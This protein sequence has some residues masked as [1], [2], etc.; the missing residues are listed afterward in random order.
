MG[1]D[2]NGIRSVESR[3]ADGGDDDNGV[4]TNER[5]KMNLP[6][7]LHGY[8]SSRPLRSPTVLVDDDTADREVWAIGRLSIEMREKSRL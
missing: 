5:R 3:F 2:E 6:S 7:N 1:C 8:S 4:R